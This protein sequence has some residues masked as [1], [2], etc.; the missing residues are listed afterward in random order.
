MCRPQALKMTIRRWE[1]TRILTNKDIDRENKILS[2]E[3]EGDILSAASYVGRVKLGAQCRQ[4][5]QQ[6]P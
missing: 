2:V 4:G 1:K 3:I 6:M 5:N